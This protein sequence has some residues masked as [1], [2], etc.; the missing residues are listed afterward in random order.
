M[1]C[2]GDIASEEVD[3]IRDYVK[4]SKLFE[5]LD[6]EK[7]LNEYIEAINREGISFLNSY[8]KELKNSDLSVEQQLLVVKIAITMIEADNVIMYSEVKFFKKVRK[9]LTIS[10]EEILAAFPDKEDFLLPDNATDDY[11]FILAADFASIH[12]DQS[13]TPQ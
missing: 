13:L 11:E 6:V 10:D 7:L 4:N 5:N 3:L 2:D 8:T 1:A 9:V 12:L